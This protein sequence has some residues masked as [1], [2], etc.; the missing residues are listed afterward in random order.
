MVAPTQEAATVSPVCKRCGDTIPAGC[1]RLF[2][3]YDCC[4]AY[5]QVVWRRV[6][7][8]QD[9]GNKVAYRKAN[10]ARVRLSGLKYRSVNRDKV[11][12]AKSKYSKF[13]PIQ[14][15]SQAQ[16]RRARKRS[17]PN[18][19]TIANWMD[20]L[21]QFAHKCAYCG[22][23]ELFSGGL[24]QEHLVPMHIGGGYVIGNIAPSCQS[25]NSS[26]GTLTAVEFIWQR[27]KRVR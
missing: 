13:N 15:S 16:R 22:V 11:R 20:V 23:D 10:R 3:C 17:L 26:K 4:N 18:T 27:H 2:C 5:K 21:A 14:R 7:R 9:L 19:F 1:R 24:S 8:D 6:H 12:L 25:C